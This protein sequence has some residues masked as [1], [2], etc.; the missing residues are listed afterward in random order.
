MFLVSITIIF[1][2][3]E[4][5]DGPL[6]AMEEKLLPSVTV[7]FQQGMSKKFRQPSGTGINLTMFEKT[8]LLKVTRTYGY[9]LAVKAKTFPNKQSGSCGRTSDFQ[10][11]S[12]YRTRIVSR[13]LWKNGVKRDLQEIYQIENSVEEDVVVHK[14]GHLCVICLSEPQD[15]VVLRFQTNRCPICSQ[16]AEM[17]LEMI[18]D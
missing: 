17:L 10:N 5:K 7:N 11:K 6:T 4:G 3:K 16:P 12:E 14:N 9:P 18:K 13:A 1:F 2:A 8:E 15:T